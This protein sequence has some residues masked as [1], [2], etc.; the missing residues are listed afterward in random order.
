MT[1]FFQ[2]FGVKSK[3]AIAPVLIV[4]AALSLGVLAWRMNVAQEH[5][6]DTLYHKSFAKKQAVSELGAT[7]LAIDAGLYRA[8]TWQ[9]AGADDATVKESI[10]ATTKLFD[11]VATTLDGLDKSI[12]G[13]S[14]DRAT[15]T[16]VR[17]AA[18][19]YLKKSRDVL[20]MLDADP[21]MAVTM[22]RQAGRLY[23]KVDQA[24]AAWSVL[25]KRDNDAL[26]DQALAEGDSSLIAF[27]LIMAAAFGGATVIILLV[28]RSLANAINTMTRVMTRLAE[29]DRDVTVAHSERRDEI[30]AMARAVQVFKEQALDNERLREAQEV[31]QA[32]AQ[33]F[34]RS[35]MLAL[36]EVLEG[37]VSISVGDISRHAERLS[38]GAVA[39]SETADELRSMAQAVGESI[40]TTSGN[41][42]TVAEATAELEASSRAISQQVQN[43]SALT[44]VARHKVERASVSVGGLTAA[45]GRIGDVVNLI[46]TIAGQTRMLALNATIEAARAGEAGRGFAVVAEEVKSL[47]LQ[48]EDGIGKVN[49]QAR[50]IGLTTS[51]AV[52]TVEAVVATIQEIDSIASEVAT[53]AERQRSATAEI[54][55][56]ATQA[57]GHTRTVADN[58]RHMLGGVD[59]TGATSRRVTALSALVNREIGALHDRLS[60][61]LRNS[62]GGNRR[63]TERVPAAISFTL[64]VDG[65]TFTGHT[66]DISHGGAMLVVN[67]GCDLQSGDGV[68]DL[69]QV[70]RVAVQVLMSSRIGLHVRFPSLESSHKAGIAQAVERTAKDDQIHIATAQDVAQNVSARF[71]QA[72]GE[73]AISL[74]DLFDADYA[75]IAG[76]A[77]EQF[78]SKHLELAERELPALLEP[79]LAAD[80]QV[81][82]CVVS[83]RNGYIGTHN[84]KYSQPQRSGD[85]AWNTANCRNRRM[86]T[87]RAAILAARSTKPHHIQTY[88]R[89]M[90]GDRWVVLKEIDAPITVQG[91]HWGAVRLAVTL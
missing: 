1:R 46:Q 86:F 31:E 14:D 56:S 83:D 89:D 7:L 87:D 38:E 11:A 65:R 26:V 58:A 21:V 25:Q 2:N 62:C 53:A 22:S 3:L 91:K 78:V 5:A 49:A 54:M 43:S 33:E 90:G 13:G 35:E 40:Q 79:P 20:D 77:P 84:R 47:A 41:V 61:I 74:D 66:A 76:S 52:E 23:S 45:T 63:A 73:G 15:F 44:E 8:I 48:T 64:S 17:D 67:G 50:E 10:G 57:A 85:V 55:A 60:V 80:P 12:D 37:E 59:R 36:S 28:G 32:R 42:Q 9:N 75:E 81:V 70:G 71:E 68:L 39:L 82:F 69:D 72:L 88:A 30:G 18:N 4:L 51:E 6:L 27:F 29:G 34:L 19:A 16:E 24:V